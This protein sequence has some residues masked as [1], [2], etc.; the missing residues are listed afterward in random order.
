M[1]RGD[2]VMSSFKPFGMWPHAWVLTQALRGFLHLLVKFRIFTLKVVNR[3]VIPKEGPVL[4]ICNHISEADPPYLWGAIPHRRT[5]IAIAA[6]ELRY[7]PGVNAVLWL[8]GHIFVN[9]KKPASRARAL[10][11]GIHV[12]E[13]GGLLFLYP[14]G[15]CSET[16]E[17]LK[18]RSG[19][20]EM[21][22]ATNALLVVAHISGSNLV[23]PVGKW[24]I[25]RAPVE[26]AFDTPIKAAD[27]VSDEELLV[28]LRKRMLVLA[29]ASK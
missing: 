1:F 14:E 5:G 8:L 6:S 9:R 17:L 23:K 18:F 25:Q 20:A 12:L 4:V 21:A 27:F 11:K 15:K 2:D 28:H 24:K 22:R 29:A 26:L 7:I 13:H 16:G 10:R 3:D 19:A